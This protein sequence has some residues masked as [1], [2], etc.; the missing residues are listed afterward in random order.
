MHITIAAE[1][2]RTAL[3]TVAGGVPS[4]SDQIPILG[5]IKVQAEASGRVRYSA[6]DLDNEVIATFQA[7]SVTEPGVLCLPGKSLQEIGKKLPD[8]TVT[9]QRE[10]ARTLL[11]CGKSR[12]TLVTHDPDAWP[13]SRP[14][15][16]SKRF[17]ISGEL[18]A[19]LAHYSAFAASK[20]DARPQLKLVLWRIS[21]DKMEMVATN[22]HECGYARGPALAAGAPEGEYLFLPKTLDLVTRLM[23][24]A[25]QIQVV[26][27]ERRAAFA[28]P[29]VQILAKLADGTFPNYRPFLEWEKTLTVTAER[30]ALLEAVQRMATVADKQVHRLVFALD[31]KGSTLSVATPD[32]GEA[33]E[34]V[35]VTVEGKPIRIGFNASY[36]EDL[37]SRF[38]SD[39]VSIDISGDRSPARI[40][41]FHAKTDAEPDAPANGGV[42]P[43]LGVM[44]LH[45]LDAAA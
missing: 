31:P 4:R 13:P 29:G 11:A 34:E 14:I 44:P 39:M 27:D 7:Q 36:L 20:D 32:L 21:K 25:E 43:M 42:E 26:L 38:D 5:T 8:Q 3:A 15:D 2:H 40:I 28:I 41:P 17:Q 45:L 24:K 33:N 6:T 23:G 37:L 9:I 12:F 35:S 30:K 10:K 18:L 16:A 1:D 19:A 22:G